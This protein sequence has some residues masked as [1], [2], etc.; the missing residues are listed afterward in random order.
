M[1]ANHLVQT[2]KS[3]FPELPFVFAEPPEAVAT[4][5]GP[6]EEMSPLKIFDDGDEATIWVGTITHSHFGNYEEGVTEDWRHQYIAENVVKFIRDLLADRVVA[7]STLG[8][9]VGGWRRL[10][11]GEALPERSR[12]KKQYLWS[13]VVR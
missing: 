8:G 11:M 7:M 10:E 9:L 13:G 1:L 4:L 2:L 3:A 12:W 5:T 6:C